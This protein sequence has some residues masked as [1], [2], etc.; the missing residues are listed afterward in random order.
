MFSSVF[1]KFLVGLCVLGFGVSATAYAETPEQLI[2]RLSSN[3]TTAVKTDAGLKNGSAARIMSYV[4]TNIMPYVDFRNMVGSVVG[5]AWGKA[6]AAE[7]N[8]L[9]VES[10]RY[11][12]RT[13]ASSLKGGDITSIDVAPTSGN[14]VRTRI[15]RNN[16]KPIA[17]TYSLRNSGGWKVYDVNVQGVSLIS[18]FR[19]QFK[20]I[21]DKSGVAGLTAY[22]KSKR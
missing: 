9:L 15:N 16:G 17:V 12:A 14:V 20:P 13:Y 8:E 2:R 11:L 22:L 7:Q 21:A 19:S 1:K 4:D 18:T 10:K 3:V 5:P 6:S